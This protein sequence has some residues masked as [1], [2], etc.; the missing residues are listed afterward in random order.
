MSYLLWIDGDSKSWLILYIAFA[1]KS[2]KLAT[3]DL[4]HRC[5]FFFFFSNFTHS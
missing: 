4:P 5:F 1:W 3:Q 2:K